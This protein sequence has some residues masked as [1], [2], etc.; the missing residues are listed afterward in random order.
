M[1]PFCTY[2][3][4]KSD[5]TGFTLLELVVVISIMMILLIFSIAPYSYYA[6]KAR[7]RLSVERIEQIM[8]KAKLLA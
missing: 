7:V 1:N 3:V 4:F 2:T 5:S 6:D 8:N